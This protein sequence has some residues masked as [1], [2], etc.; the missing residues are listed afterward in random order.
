MEA[1]GEAVVEDDDD[2]DGD[3]VSHGVVPEEDAAEDDDEAAPV[4]CAE[5]RD[6]GGEVRELPD[7]GVVEE[8]GVT[9]VAAV[10]EVG[11]A[12]GEA[13]LASAAA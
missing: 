2:E 1:C 8:D 10:K 13:V 9:E 5:E 11:G 12:S 3:D 4:E 7:A 6:D